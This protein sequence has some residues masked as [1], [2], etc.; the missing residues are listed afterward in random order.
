MAT[1]S[2]S[3]TGTGDCEG[4]EK[5]DSSSHPEVLELTENLN[6]LSV[7]KNQKDYEDELSQFR[8]QW[9]RELEASPSHHKDVTKPVP[10]SKDSSLQS[11]EDQ[12]KSLYLLGIEMENGGKLYEAIKHYKKALQI[13]PDVEAKLYAGREQKIV[14]RA[15]EEEEV[16]NNTVADDSDDDDA[17]EGEEFVSRIKRKGYLLQTNYPTKGGHMSWL[18]Y[19]VLQLILRWVVSSDLDSVSLERVSAVCRGFYVAAR[20]DELWRSMCIRTWGAECGTPRLHKFTSWRQMY[21]ERPRLNLNGCYI[22]KTTYLRPGENSFQD[23]FYRPWYFINYFRYLRFFPEGLVLMWTTPDEPINCLSHLKYRNAKHS[24]GIMSG[25]YRLF[26]NKVIIV[27]KKS[28]AEKKAPQTSNR[29]FRARRKET[30]EQE[31]MYHI[32]LE[33]C[34]VRYR[35]NWSLVWKHYAVSTRG[36]WSHFEL[37]VRKFPSFVFSPVRNYTAESNEPL[38]S[39]S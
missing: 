19:E 11:K 35:R 33:L 12:A 30:H 36:Q 27:I 4:E 25:H 10:D 31:Q 1:G 6:S 37:G 24:Q 39:Y 23:Q 13:C 3:G 29:R 32:E 21:I 18:P 5:D 28:N 8:Q 2:G 9:Q 14:A 26:E 15:E 17:V 34:N 7:D 16:T 20:A 22:S 38:T